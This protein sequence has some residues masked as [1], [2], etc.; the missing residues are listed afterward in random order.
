MSIVQDHWLQTAAVSHLGLGTPNPRAL[1]AFYERTVGL[2]LREAVGTPS[3]VASGVDHEAGDSAPI[4]LGWGATGHHVLELLPGEAGLDHFGVE[5]PDQADLLRLRER[6]QAHGVGTTELNSPELSGFSIDDPDGNCIHL[7]GRIDR[8]GE[9][10]A[11][12]GRRPIRYQHA[13]LATANLTKMISFYVDILGFR[14]TDRMGDVFA[15]LR[16]GRDHHIIAIVDTGAGGDIDHYSYDVSCW[17]DFK[18]WCDRLAELKVP[19]SWGPGR[20]G[21][22]NNLFIMFDDPDGRHVE[23]SAEMERFWD[24]LSA[25]EPRVWTP[26]AVTVNLWGGQIPSWRKPTRA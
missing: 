25:Y 9:H 18:T 16:A 7:H 21:P 5:I 8:T 10:T 20:H 6:L 4:Q 22:G 2:Q 11:D 1:A 3:T 15:W 12:P 23:L 14:L 17:E 19:I 13:T 26:D 24:D